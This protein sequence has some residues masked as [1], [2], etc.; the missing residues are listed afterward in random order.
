MTIRE[1]LSKAKY[2]VVFRIIDHGAEYVETNWV[3]GTA[4]FLLCNLRDAL[5][6]ETF[7]YFYAGTNSVITIYLEEC[8]FVFDENPNLK[9]QGEEANVCI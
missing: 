7:A 3:E 4:E 6:N 5:L 1:L 8:R 2:D 9:V